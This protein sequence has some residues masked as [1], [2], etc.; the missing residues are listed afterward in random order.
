MAKGELSNGI[1]LFSQ[2]HERKS[3]QAIKTSY[4]DVP[5]KMKEQ[6]FNATRW[7]FPHFTQSVSFLT[8]LYLMSSLRSS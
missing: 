2:M 1:A 3:F 4:D 7:H 8:P 5:S 6:A